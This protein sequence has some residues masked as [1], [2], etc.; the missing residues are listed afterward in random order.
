MWKRTRT[1]QQKLTEVLSGINRKLIISSIAAG[2]FVEKI[3]M[4][5]P[6]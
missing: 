1:V 5:L 2:Y 3:L 4:A 6:L